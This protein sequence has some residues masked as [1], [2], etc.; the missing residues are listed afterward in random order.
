MVKFVCIYSRSVTTSQ[1]SIM[2][3]GQHFLHSASGY[4]GPVPGGSGGVVGAGP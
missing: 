3:D 4:L 1:A 2:P